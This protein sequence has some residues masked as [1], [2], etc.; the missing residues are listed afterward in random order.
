MPTIQLPP[1]MPR[2]MIRLPLDDVGR[3]VPFFVEWIDGKPDFR[4]MNLD[5][6]RAA[7]RR[8][9]CWVCGNR[10]PS[11][12]LRLGKIEVLGLRP[13]TFV[14]GPMCLVNKVSAEPPSH[15][16]CAQWAARACPFLSNPEKRR[17]EGGIDQSQVGTIGGTAI[18][19]NPGVTGLFHVKRWWVERVPNGQVIRFDSVV[20]ADWLCE[21]REATPGEVRASIDS[22]LPAVREVAESEG[23]EAVAQLRAAV[24][25]SERWLP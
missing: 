12:Q 13:H 10:L 18:M 8:R 17:R 1:G 23:P 19:R 5:S 11:S 9:L 4:V 2:E 21:G 24:R 7:I 25:E 14:A 6:Y 15:P 20:H 16:R 3:P 22:G